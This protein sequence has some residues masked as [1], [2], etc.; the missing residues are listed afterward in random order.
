MNLGKGRSKR[1]RSRRGGKNRKEGGKVG[2]SSAGGNEIAGEAADKRG[3]GGVEKA[4]SEADTQEEMD[5][6]N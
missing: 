2:T 5:K 6:N 3:V 1:A 4:T